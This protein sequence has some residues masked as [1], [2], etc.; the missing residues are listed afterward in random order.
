MKAIITLIFFSL[1]VVAFAGGVSGGKS[2]VPTQHST[3]SSQQ[4]LSMATKMSEQLKVKL[5]LSTFQRDALKR[6]LYSFL[7]KKSAIVPMIQTNYAEYTYRH[8]RIMNDFRK[9]MDFFFYE[10][11]KKNFHALKP[12]SYDPS[13]PYSYIFY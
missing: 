10:V 2:D 4:L 5:D 6:S 7:Q 12:A 8:N 1:S 9:E 3:Y 13:N 11:D